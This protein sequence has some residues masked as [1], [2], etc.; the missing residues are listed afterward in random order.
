MKGLINI[1]KNDKKCFLWCN[2]RH[3]NCKGVEL[4]RITKE[5]KKISKSL[6]YDKIEYRL[7]KK[8]YN[9]IE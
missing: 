6:N 5:D 2:V 4:S 8:D 9:K 3:L 1:Q 7:S